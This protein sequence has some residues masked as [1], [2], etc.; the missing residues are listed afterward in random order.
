MKKILFA[1]LLFCG[2]TSFAQN[3]CGHLKANAM[4]A[5]FTLTVAD[6]D[7]LNQY[8]LNYYKF[9]LDVE[10]N[11]KYIQGSVYLEAVTLATM[12]TFTLQLHN[13]LTVD[14]VWFNQKK[15]DAIHDKNFL[16]IE[17]DADSLLANTPFNATIFYHGTTPTN[18]NGAVGGSAFNTNATQ[19]VTWTLSQPFSAYEW[20]PCKQ[21]NT[22]KIDSV[23]MWINTD[24]I[25]KVGSNGLL[26]NIVPLGNGKHSYHWFSKY[27]VAHYLI[28]IAV[29][30]YQEINSYANVPGHAPILVQNYMYKNATAPEF[31]AIAHTPALIELF[32]KKFGMY[33]FAN[34]KYGHS[35]APIQGAMEHQTMTSI[36]AFNFDIVAHELGHQY[37]GDY[38]TCHG[39]SEVWLNEGFATFTEYVALEN[40]FPGE[41]K[42]WLLGMMNRAKQANGTV[43]V[44]DSFDVETLFDGSSS[45]AKGGM[46][47]HM[48]RNLINNDSIFFLGLRNYL[49]AYAFGSARTP[50]LKE[51]MEQT[52]GLNLDQFFEQWIYNEGYPILSG[53]WNQVGGNLWLSINQEPSRGSTVFQ[54]PLEVRLKRA[55]GDTSIFVQVN[56]ASKMLNI[57]VGM[58]SIQS[59]RFD[60]NTKL[61]RDVFS[62]ANDPNFTSLSDLSEEFANIVLYPNPA[63]NQ[64][65]INQAAGTH[66]QIIDMR[67][68]LVQTNALLANEQVIDIASLLPGV[69]VIQ[70]RKNESTATLRFVKQ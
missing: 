7:L 5:D 59:I 34:E 15:S 30:P 3:S 32:S 68:Q 51:I 17:A 40:L 62:I 8:N 47:V 29:S 69:Y 70:F 66:M 49:A 24:T 64:L 23:D 31:D 52:S 45:Y 42:D 21:L 9:N 38:V 63:N 39:Y 53:K 54:F 4:S 2:L 16:H 25:N 57:P 67:G 11:S 60:P 36:G 27:P 43:F 28:S 12:H 55:M 1:T 58:G 41:E 48:L 35:Q 56:A 13:D 6:M 14:S 19:K 10:N 22:D 18:T 20:F 44:N 26:K 37:F 65:N 46:V 33:P 50:N 61:L